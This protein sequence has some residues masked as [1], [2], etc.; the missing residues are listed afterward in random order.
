[1]KVL[2]NVDRVK[3]T[4]AGINTSSR[5]VIVDVNPSSVALLDEWSGTASS[6]ILEELAQRLAEVDGEDCREYGPNIMKV[7][8]RTVDGGFYSNMLV[9][10]ESPT[11]EGLFKAM[12]D[13]RAN[14]A[15]EALAKMEAKKQAAAEIHANTLKVLESNKTRTVSKQLCAWRTKEG[16]KYGDWAKSP[17]HTADERCL[18]VKYDVI[19]PDWPYHADASVKAFPETLAWLNRLK[20]KNSLALADAHIAATNRLVEFEKRKA[21]EKA[22]KERL[23]HAKSVQIAQWV[24][25]HATP[26][27]TERWEA[28]LLPEKEVTDA[29]CAD[30]F[31]PIDHL[32]KTNFTYRDYR[33]DS[34][35]ECDLS[36]ANELTADEFATMKMVKSL[37]PGAKVVANVHTCTM[38]GSGEEIVR[39]SIMVS[40]N[41]GAFTFSRRLAC[42]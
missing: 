37:M 10:A 33:D 14:L 24:M 31:K 28:G 17:Y 38:D 1:M 32:P 13:E 21:D 3:A 15:N 12:I 2:F 42:P 41:L 40:I 39:K 9:V 34:A 35:V 23:D 16:V 8:S 7:R 27:Q 36:E 30:V 5:K 18:L 6:A 4:A 19:E 29:L 22:E 26:E 25:S 20:V 11:M